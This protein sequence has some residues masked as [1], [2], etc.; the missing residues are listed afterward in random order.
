MD[1]NKLI[2]LL[3]LMLGFAVVITATVLSKNYQYWH[4]LEVLTVLAAILFY[5][6]GALTSAALTILIGAWLFSVTPATLFDFL[7]LLAIT[8]IVGWYAGWQ[9]NSKEQLGKMT[10]VDRLTGL[11]NYS[12]FVDRLEEEKQRA[13]RFGSQVAVIMFDIDYFKPYND[14]Y[15]HRQGNEFLKKVTTL[16]KAGVRAVD[17]VCR[18]GGEEFVVILPNTGETAFEVAERVRQLI[19]EHDFKVAAT[20]DIEKKTISA[21]V[22]IYPDHAGDEI[23][24]IDRADEALYKAKNEGRNQVVLWNRDLAKA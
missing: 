15:G 11:Y 16:I 3:V 22:A 19:E 2:A 9:Q 21:G 8:V 17:V 20:G 12:Y 23:E 10:T 13:D 5:L 7:R 1:R 6:P 4:G 24:L 18:Y 14:K